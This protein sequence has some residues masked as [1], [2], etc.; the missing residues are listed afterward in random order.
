MFQ[1]GR[2]YDVY[3]CTPGPERYGEAQNSGWIVLE[4]SAANVKFQTHRGEV[5][6]NIDS[7]LFSRAILRD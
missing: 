2:K 7:P 3:L 5:I 6:V 4:I 1:I